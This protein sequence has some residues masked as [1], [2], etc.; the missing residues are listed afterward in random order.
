MYI[1]I[2]RVPVIHPVN[3]NYYL[4]GVSTSLW[5]DDYPPS[6]FGTAQVAHKTRDCHRTWID[7]G[8][9]PIWTPGPSDCCGRILYLYKMSGF[10]SSNVTSTSH[11]SSKDEFLNRLGTFESCLAVHLSKGSSVSWTKNKLKMQTKKMMSPEFA[12]M[13]SGNSIRSSNWLCSFKPWRLQ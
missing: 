7:P 8:L 3:G 6:H 10:P 12:I 11:L 9:S 2:Y 1:Y 4:M 5:I 13:W